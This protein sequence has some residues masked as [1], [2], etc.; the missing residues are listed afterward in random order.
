MPV[1]SSE[2]DVYGYTAENRHM[3]EC[4]LKDVRTKENFSDGVAITELLMTAYM[5]AEQGVTIKFPPPGLDQFVP[6]VAKGKL[7]LLTR[8]SILMQLPT[9]LLCIKSTDFCPPSHAPQDEATP[10]SSV[11]KTIGRICALSCTRLIKWAC[12]ASGT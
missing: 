1:V 3:V 12:P 10:S 7:Q 5:S 8:L 4:S 11:V 9:P 6:M 2:A